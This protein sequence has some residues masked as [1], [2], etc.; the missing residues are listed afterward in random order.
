MYKPEKDERTRTSASVAPL[1]FHW[2]LCSLR[3]LL[4]SKITVILL[5]NPI[6][7]LPSPQ[8]HASSKPD[9]LAVQQPKL[10][11]SCQEIHGLCF[12]I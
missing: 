9:L 3:Y 5:I 2:S 1:R 12:L 4:L 11:A 8:S 7:K 6:R 10:P